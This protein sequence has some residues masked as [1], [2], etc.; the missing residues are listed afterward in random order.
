MIST[1]QLL[2]LIKHIGVP[3]AIA[4]ALPVPSCYGVKARR[5]LPTH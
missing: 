5:V 2:E 1:Q 3:T 4:H